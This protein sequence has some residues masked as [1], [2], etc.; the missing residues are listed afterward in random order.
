[1]LLLTVNSQQKVGDE[2]GK[3]LYHQPIPAS[4]KKMIYVE[5]PF[6]PGEKRF[7]VPAELISKSDL[8]C[9]EIKTIGGKSIVAALYSIPNK[10]ERFMGLIDTRGAEQNL[11]IKE[12]MGTFRNMMF[13]KYLLKISASRP[14]M[15]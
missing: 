2:T 5:I 3:Y 12:H 13:N 9:G 6:P 14:S 11:C 15:I 8:H 4:G 1:M 10:T 7:D